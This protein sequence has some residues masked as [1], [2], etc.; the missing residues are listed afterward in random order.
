MSKAKKPGFSLSDLASEGA[1]EAQDAPRTAATPARAEPPAT[2]S[3]L[4]RKA[5]PKAINI[6]VTPADHKRLSMLA[7]NQETK[8]QR[9]GHEAWNLLLKH[10]GLPELEPEKAPSNAA[11]KRE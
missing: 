5:R 8:L 4:A 11:R 6:Y 1:D 10:Y 2:A 9:L 3:P 7:V